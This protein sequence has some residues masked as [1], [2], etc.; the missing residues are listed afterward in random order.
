MNFPCLEN[1]LLDIILTK[2]AGDTGLQGE[3]RVGQGPTTAS[4]QVLPT[5]DQNSLSCRSCFANTVKLVTKA[6]DNFQIS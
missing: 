2:A 1:S 4:P 6:D 5:S 3:E